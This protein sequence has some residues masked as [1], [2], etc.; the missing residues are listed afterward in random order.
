M[1]RMKPWFHFFSLEIILQ[2][3]ISDLMVFFHDPGRKADQLL[4]SQESN[5][6]AEL[7]HF[8]KLEGQMR[9]TFNGPLQ[10]VG[11]CT[12]PYT[13]TRIILSMLPLTKDHMIRYILLVLK[14]VLRGCLK[15]HCS[16]TWMGS[17]CPIKGPRFESL[18]ALCPIVG[19]FLADLPS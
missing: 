4:T 8:P 6:S 2:I 13:I 12:L 18:E 5:A 11:P 7:P 3:F 19:H 17:P 15:P 1:T 9:I 14:C 10:H 16:L